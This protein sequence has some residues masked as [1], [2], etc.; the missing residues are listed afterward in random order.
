VSSRVPSNISDV[1][2][3]PISTPVDPTEE[4]ANKLMKSFMGTLS[5]A[6]RAANES[7]VAGLEKAVREQ[8]RSFISAVK[9]VQRRVEDGSTSLEDVTREGVAVMKKMQ[10]GIA[11]NMGELKEKMSTFSNP[12]PKKKGWVSKPAKDLFRIGGVVIRDL[13]VF[14][15]NMV[16]AGTVVKNSKGWHKPILFKEVVVSAGELSSPGTRRDAVGCP[17]VGLNVPEVSRVLQKRMVAETGRTNGTVL[18]QSAFGEVFE[19]FAANKGCEYTN[20]D[21]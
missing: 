19:V 6:G 17:V 18:L 8:K 9:H 21:T 1:P 11:E 10:K 2:S 7:G 12:P 14:M 20:V 16:A 3:S 4:K 15:R 5:R 13:R